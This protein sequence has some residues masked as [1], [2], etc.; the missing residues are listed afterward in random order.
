MQ[1]LKILSSSERLRQ[2]RKSI[3]TTLTHLE[4]ERRQVEESTEW[5]DRLAYRNRISLLDR[6]AHWYHEEMGQI[7]KA[8]GG[9]HARTYGVCAACKE[10]IE[11]ERLEFD[12]HAEFCS[13]CEEYQ[14]TLKAE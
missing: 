2:R 14:A 6:L 12:P 5:M 3:E 13:E 8:L 4:N 1:D 10:P 9:S 7:D 11:A